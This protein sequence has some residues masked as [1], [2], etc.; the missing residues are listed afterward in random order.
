MRIRRL[1]L[2]YQTA[3]APH[4]ATRSPRLLG[5]PSWLEAADGARDGESVGNPVKSSVSATAQGSQR[6]LDLLSLLTSR[7]TTVLLPEATRGSIVTLGSAARSIAVLIELASNHSLQPSCYSFFRPEKTA[8]IRSEANSEAAS[9]LLMEKHLVNLAGK[10]RLHLAHAATQTQLDTSTI[11]NVLYVCKLRRVVL[12][13]GGGS[14]PLSAAST[15]SGD[16]GWILPIGLRTGLMDAL[17]MNLETSATGSALFSPKVLVSLLQSLSSCG[18]Q[19]RC[20]EAT[21][22]SNDGGDGKGN[23]TTS[24]FQHLFEI[25]MTAI[26][27]RISFLDHQDVVQLLCVCH[28]VGEGVWKRNYGGLVAGLVARLPM[29]IGRL[30]ERSL[31]G[32]AAICAS[33]TG[34][35]GQQVDDTVKSAICNAALKYL[36]DDD[37]SSGMSEGEADVENDGAAGTFSSNRSPS[38]PAGNSSVRCSPESLLRLLVLA[39]TISRVDLRTIALKQ[40]LRHVANFP[41]HSLA[42]SSATVIGLLRLLSD[43]PLSGPGGGVEV[44]RAL[45]G[46]YRAIGTIFV[47]LETVG[48]EMAV[49]LLVTALGKAE[50]T[51][52][53]GSERS[54]AVGSAML[55]ALMTSLERRVSE[56]ST[57]DKLRIIAA[58]AARQELLFLIPDA[59]EQ[60]PMASQLGGRSSSSSSCVN[61]V[62]LHTAPPSNTVLSGAIG[63]R[64]LRALQLQLPASLLT[65]TP[66]LDLRRCLL[67]VARVS[68]ERGIEKSLHCSI[69]TCILQSLCEEESTRYGGQSRAK[70]GFPS[71]VEVEAPNVTTGAHHYEILALLPS[72]KLNDVSSGNNTLS[73]PQSQ[74][75]QDLL[76]SDERWRQICRM[77][78]AAVAGLSLDEDNR[79]QEADNRQLGNS[80]V[81]KKNFPSLIFDPRILTELVVTRVANMSSVIAFYQLAVKQQQA[82]FLSLPAEEIGAEF[83]MLFEAAGEEDTLSSSCQSVQDHNNHRHHK[84]LT[85][86]DR[87]RPALHPGFDARALL[88][89]DRI[90][91]DFALDDQKDSANSTS[92]AARP[93]L[94]SFL[95]VLDYFATSPTPPPAASAMPSPAAQATSVSG[96]VTAAKVSPVS[97]AAATAAV[98]GSNDIAVDNEAL[99]RLRSADQLQ[100]TIAHILCRLRSSPLETLFTAAAAASSSRFNDHFG[101]LVL[102][103]EQEEKEALKSKSEEGKSFLHNLTLPEL[104]QLLN[105]VICRIDSTTNEALANRIVSHVVHHHVHHQAHYHLLVQVAQAAASFGK[106]PRL[107][108]ILLGSVVDQA[109]VLKASK[110]VSIKPVQA[111]QLIVLVNI[112]A[113]LLNHS[114]SDVT[115]KSPGVGAIR[116]GEVNDDDDDHLMHP[117]VRRLVHCWRSQAVDDFCEL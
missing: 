41:P 117:L 104:L 26:R 78:W 38:R 110:S 86:R 45:E 14:S 25:W 65:V 77:S 76:R 79:Q 48:T 49:E 108:E 18:L 55:C 29:I 8:G 61:H 62:L 98:S 67:P 92:D 54:G 103:Q 112:A 59:A 12:Q 24:S 1:A 95:N 15:S 100:S 9:T 73:V 115:M 70:G 5:S 30:N 109:I 31:G 37:T 72:L 88:L 21:K 36:V 80:S 99:S 33:S 96:S 89:L 39:Q 107:V 116:E 27:F 10:L 44:Q 69:S 35:I 4:F 87:T 111:A 19:Q 20:G 51:S 68:S 3:F 6:S 57:A 17:Q 74:R 66:R 93:A 101:S 114:S 75:D 28:A 32:L 13:H 102:S 83:R 94:R 63:H 2:V 106:F 16:L 84:S 58:V 50:S 43:V 40:L 42:K 23:T 105:L 47:D 64:L 85:G 82:Y 113:A 53:I 60:L 52:S 56:L 46:L 91:H 22:S 34:G 81:T 11:M 97:P 7:M 71:I 90:A